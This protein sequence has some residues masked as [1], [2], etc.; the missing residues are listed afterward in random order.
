MKPVSLRGQLTLVAGGYA[1]VLAFASVLVVGR[2]LLYVRHPEDVAAAGG[3]YA[4]GDA[5][6]ALFIAGLLMIPTLV[7]AIL[8][9]KSEDLYTRYAKVLAG[10]SLTAPVGL[11]VLS[12][13]AVNQSNSMLGQVCMY[14]LLCGPVF[15]VGMVISRVLARSPQA[16][17]WTSCA[18]AIEFLTM[19][20][21]VGMLLFPLWF[22]G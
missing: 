6:L 10:F 5:M 17:R 8:L 22:K 9:R 14:R 7:L 19:A 3:M 15:L 13:P 18:V 12:I 21:E 2:Y 16:K 20:V 11:G 1:V 4:A